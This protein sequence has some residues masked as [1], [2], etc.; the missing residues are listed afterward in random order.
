MCVL[1]VG[2]SPW[3]VH[4]G[5][6]VTKEMTVERSWSER[7]IPNFISTV[8]GQSLKFRSLRASLHAAS[9]SLPLGLSVCTAVLWAPLSAQPSSRPLC[10][11]SRPTQPSS[12]SVS[13]LP[14]LQ[15][16]LCDP[17]A[18]QPCHHVVQSTGQNSLYTVN[19][20]ILP[21]GVE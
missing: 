18:L 21:T 15:P 10:L 11:H 17:A 16:L 9:W 4:Y 12:G 5:F 7:V 8:A 13:V 1:P 3:Q 2:F 19:S 14:P 20:N 6:S